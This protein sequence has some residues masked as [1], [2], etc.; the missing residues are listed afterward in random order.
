M[1]EIPGVIVAAYFIVRGR[2]LADPSRIEN[3]N[4]A[5]EVSV[6]IGSVSDAV[7]TETGVTQLVFLVSLVV[8]IV[9]YGIQRRWVLRESTTVAIDR[10]AA[11]FA[12]GWAVCPPARV[13]GAR[14]LRQAGVPVA[15]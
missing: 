8:V 4:W 6:L 13:P 7:L 1:T 9:L 15:R 5:G 3:V 14:Y 11:V 10:A 12:D 2:R